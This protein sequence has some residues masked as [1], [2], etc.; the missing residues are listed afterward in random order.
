MLNPRLTI[1]RWLTAPLTLSLIVALVVISSA[2]A[3]PTG[4]LHGPT[5]RSKSSALRIELNGQFD[6]ATSTVSGTWQATGAITGTGR[7]FEHVTFTG[8]PVPGAQGV[9]IHLSKLLWNQTGSILLRVDALTDVS[10]AGIATF[11][12]GS[13]RVVGGTGAYADLR[14]GGRPAATDDSFASLVTGQVHIVHAGS[15]RQD[16]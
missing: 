12:G 9:P 8:Q 10:P 14:A 1:P 4:D 2:S 16:D 5:D 7:Y 3:R 11:P 6:P 15:L 13:W